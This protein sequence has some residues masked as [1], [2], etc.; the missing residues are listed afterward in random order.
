MNLLRQSVLA[1]G[2]K[3]L[4]NSAVRE[5]MAIQSGADAVGERLLGGEPS[6]IVAG[7]E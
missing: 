4:L 7:R 3:L 2:N 5:R 1:D 6:A